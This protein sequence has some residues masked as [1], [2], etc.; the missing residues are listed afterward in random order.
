MGTE[1]LEQEQDKGTFTPLDE[2]IK[3]LDGPD[4]DGDIPEGEFGD[5][6][7]DDKAESDDSQKADDKK[8]EEASEEDDGKAKKDED[9]DE[10]EADAAD[11][12]EDKGDKKEPEPDPKDVEISNLRASTRKLT[13]EYRE[14]KESYEKLNKRIEES[15]LAPAKEEEGSEEAA[16]L[17]EAMKIKLETLA[18]SMK[19]QPQYADLDDVVT[20]ERYQDTIEGAVANLVKDGYSESEAYN[21]A[22][23][24][25]WSRPNPYKY[26]YELIKGGHPDF[27]KSKDAGDKDAEGKDKKKDVKKADK[28]VAPSIDKAPGGGNKD[29][30]GWTTARIDDLPE[31]ELHKVPPDV[32]DKYMK[33]ELD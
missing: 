17:E 16:H 33:G 6:A 14:L 8:E 11:A 26:L 29:K 24:Y 4:L 1:E 21:L 5:E 25:V 20:E 30:G 9:K 22:N 10:G 27:A 15:G 28:D 23:N 2:M 7:T 31:D 32:Y 18:E 3:G 13:K 19:L 12:G